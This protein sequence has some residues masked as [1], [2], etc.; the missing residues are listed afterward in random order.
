MSK[1]SP[2]GSR[3]R[4]R[5][6]RRIA[7]VLVLCASVLA[8]AAASAATAPPFVPQLVI[9]DDVF[10]ASSAL[11][12]ADIQAFL[13]RYP[14]GL[15]TTLAPRHA[16]GTMQPVS[17][18]IWEVA[19]EFNINPKVL[20]VT[21]QK[22]QSLI[23]KTAPSQTTLDWA[24]G[25]GCYDGST[26]ETRDPK[27][28]GL[29]NQ[30]WYAARAL[31]SYAETTWTPGLKRTICINCVTT[32]YTPDVNFVAQNISTYKLYVYT[33]H[34]HGPTSDIYGGNY[35]FWT[36]YWKYFD[37]GPLQSAALK[38]V[39]RFYN[40]VAGT[41][42]YTASEAERYNVMRRMSATFTYEGPAYRVNT[43]NPVNSSPLYRFFNKKNGTHFY[44]ASEAEKQ[45][46]IDRMSATFTFEGP[47]YNVSTVPD[48]ADPMFRLYDRRTGTH[49][50]TTSAEERDAAA[51]RPGTTYIY[52]G[53]AYYIGK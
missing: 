25:F 50:Y 39:Y 2:A 29:G 14:G 4:I 23:T 30:I 46:V 26:P 36:T 1:P 34:S 9:A 42:F 32:P 47:V 15:D 12:V 7:A 33:P 10:R 8:P 3:S 52:E 41:H 13:E 6:F 37:E 45:S 18:L 16:D 38:P 43:A 27:Y 44:T 19:Q 21:L 48:N 31:D 24:L 35:L 40:K 5:A 28:K 51:N 20:L 49:F 22:E 53:I 17:L 11:E